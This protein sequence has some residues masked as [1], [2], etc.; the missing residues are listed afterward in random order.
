MKN[1][2]SFLQSFCGKNPTYYIYC[3][4]VSR[5][6]PYRLIWKMSYRY[7]SV[8]A[9]KKIEYIGLYWYGPIWKKLIGRTLKQM[10]QFFLI[11]GWMTFFSKVFLDTYSN[12]N[13][14]K[15]NW[16]SS[17]SYWVCHAH[18]TNHWK[19]QLAKNRTFDTTYLE[20]LWTYRRF[21]LYPWANQ[22]S[23]LFEGQWYTGEM[24]CQ[25]W[26]LWSGWK[27]W[28]PRRSTGTFND[29][30]FATLPM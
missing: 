19:C 17:V 10:L 25:I 1:H 28:T 29:V 2:N 21:I 27:K 5:H 30:W 3:I 13:S 14:M 9:D 15:N 16:I 23:C 8:S 20:L 26:A 4:S 7:L 12:K 6:Y 22:K 24:V 18:L 11:K